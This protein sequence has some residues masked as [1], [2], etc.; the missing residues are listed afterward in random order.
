MRGRTVGSANRF[1]TLKLLGL[2]GA[3]VMREVNTDEA[4]SYTW[5]HVLFL[6]VLYPPAFCG[7]LFHLLPYRLTG[8]LARAMAAKE[9]LVA[10]TKLYV[11]LFAFPF[12]MPFKRGFSGGP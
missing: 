9:D 5:K 1:R 12:F 10:T 7:W 8:P 4:L 3:D 6:T 2:E 11:R